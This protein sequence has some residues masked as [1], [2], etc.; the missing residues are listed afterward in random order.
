MNIE[1]ASLV[2]IIIDCIRVAQT[3]E[4]LFVMMRTSSRLT[5]FDA[6]H[7]PRATVSNFRP[8][9]CCVRAALLTITSFEITV[10]D[11]A[12]RMMMLIE[13]RNN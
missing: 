2:S 3:F 1:S 12:F 13:F 6:V 7:C 10:H 8:N 5:L 11:A 9:N 4:Q